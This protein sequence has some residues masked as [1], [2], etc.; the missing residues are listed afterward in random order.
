MS[1]HISKK[2]PNCGFVYESRHYAFVPSKDNQ[3]VYGSPIKRC[4]KC[5]Q[6]FVDKNYR[7]I[8]VQGV[9]HVDEMYVSPQTLVSGGIPMIISL[10][11][12]LVLFMN[13]DEGVL[14]SMIVFVFSL[15]LI[16]SEMVGH[17][18]R[19]IS[20]KKEEEESKMRLQNPKYA[21]MLQQLGYDVP[22]Y[23][24]ADNYPVD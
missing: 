17:K 6:L 10:I 7:E 4:E 23:Y 19:M 12:S 13:G 21:R 14:T 18:K 3:T 15:S 22:S 5:G 16:I 11:T 9:R 1:T 2:C 20:L 24:L 8:A